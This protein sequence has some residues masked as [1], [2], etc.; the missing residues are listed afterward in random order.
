[1]S[2]RS[3]RLRDL[4]SQQGL[5][6]PDIAKMTGKTTRTVGR[7]LSEKEDYEPSD[8]DLLLISRETKRPFEWLNGEQDVL[9]EAA[10]S[11]SEEVDVASASDQAAEQAELTTAH[12]YPAYELRDE[13]GQTLFRVDVVLRVGPSRRQTVKLG[14]GQQ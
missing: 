8:G 4:M 11:E 13:Q 10:E 2:P 3:I 7:W 5:S 14:G 6:R 9:S 1:M 12:V